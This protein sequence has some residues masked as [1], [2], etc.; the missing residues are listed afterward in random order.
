LANISIQQLEGER[1]DTKEEKNT[2]YDKQKLKKLKEQ[3][4][5]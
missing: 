4:L 3:R 2:E 1:R 5:D